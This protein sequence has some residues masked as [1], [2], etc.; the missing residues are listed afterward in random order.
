MGQDYEKINNTTTAGP[1]D[2][3]SLSGKNKTMLIRIA[4]Q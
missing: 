2:D 1:D 4:S 3:K